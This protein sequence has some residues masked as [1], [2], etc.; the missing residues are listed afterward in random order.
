MLLSSKLN[1]DCTLTNEG[2][3]GGNSTDRA[4][5]EFFIS[6]SRPLP[7]VVS[8]T[9]FKSENKYSSVSL[10][11]GRVLIKG[12]PEAI[13][14][15]CSLSYTDDG[16]IYASSLARVRQEYSQAVLSGERV[17]AVAIGNNEQPDRLTFVGLIVLRDRLRPGV[18]ESVAS[19][20]R[21]GVQTV[22]L[23]GDN[24][25]TAISIAEECGFY[26][27][28]FGHIA[29]T[30]DELALLSDAELEDM[31][32]KIR[33][34]ARA[35]PQDKVRLVNISAKSNLVVGMTGDGINDAPALKLA[36]VGFAMG[37]GTDIAKSAADIVILDNSFE[38]ISK[39]ILYGRTIFKSIRKFITFQLIMNLAACGITLLGP[40]FGID[41]PITIIQMLWVNIIMDTLGG[42]AFAGEAPLKYYMLEKPKKR[43]EPILSKEMI[44]HVLL[45]GAYTLALLVFFLNFR[46]LRIFYG[47]PQRHLSAFYALFIFSGIVNSFTARSERMFIFFGILKNKAYLFIMSLITV[48][49]IVIVYFGGSLFRSTPLTFYELGLVV[50][51]SFTVFVFDGVRRVFQKLK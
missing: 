48:I 9:A 12:A 1:T 16:A 47:S 21:A 49:Q 17:I 32:P 11:D 20:M 37:S 34:V 10:E 36:D 31:L 5:A 50:L 29:L 7:R 44:S 41:A 35:L 30:S 46:P 40:Y 8:K 14:S 4:I 23:T 22:M 38:A 13:L 26:K 19:V 43:E 18:R 15:I 39:T 33:I 3:I 42:L 25:D 24:K 45:N 28:N 51:L 27:K 2:V 6:E